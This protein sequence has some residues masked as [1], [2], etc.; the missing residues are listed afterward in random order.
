MEDDPVVG[1][2]RKEIT[3]IDHAIFAALNQRIE[4][5]A[6]L[7]R[8]KEDKGYSFLDPGREQAM[9]DEQVALNEGP[10]SEAGLRAFYA[11]LLALIKREVS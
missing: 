9:V 7:R 3:E 10:L 2:A 11:E 1:N 4:V 8:Y 5:V 6:E